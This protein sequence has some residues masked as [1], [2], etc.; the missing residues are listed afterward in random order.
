[1]LIYFKNDCCSEID[2]GPPAH[3]D[4]SRRS[5]Q[6]ERVTREI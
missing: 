5:T 2:D 1:M 6:S 3:L 4:S